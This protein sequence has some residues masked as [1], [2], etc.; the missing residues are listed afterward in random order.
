MHGILKSALKLKGIRIAKQQ[1]FKASEL[2]NILTTLETIS[3]QG[4][5]SIEYLAT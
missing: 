4:I 3:L 2:E 1:F 5:G